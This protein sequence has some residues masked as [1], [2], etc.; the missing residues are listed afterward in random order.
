MRKRIQ[1]EHA[2]P[3]YRE[4]KNSKYNG[5]VLEDGSIRVGKDYYLDVKTNMVCKIK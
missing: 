2:S 3:L 1:C 5:K 4:V